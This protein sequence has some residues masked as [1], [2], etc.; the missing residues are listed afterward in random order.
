MQHA[1]AELPRW[2][3]DHV[4]GQ[5][6]GEKRG[7]DAGRNRCAQARASRRARAGWFSE[8]ACARGPTPGLGPARWALVSMP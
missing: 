4:L 6:W 5:P 1:G 3:A 8:S 2:S 7:K